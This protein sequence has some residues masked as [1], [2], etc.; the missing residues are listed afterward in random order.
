MENG[1]RDRNDVVAGKLHNVFSYT[2]LPTGVVF[3]ILLFGVAVHAH[4][5]AHVVGRAIAVYCAIVSVVMTTLLVY[6]HLMTYTQPSQQRLIIRILLMVPIYAVDSCLAL[7]NYRHAALV[8]LVRDTYEAY[9]I[10]N[11]FHLLMAY[12]GGEQKALAAKTGTSVKHIFPLCC[13]PDFPLSQ[14]TM[15]FWKL[16]LLQYLIVKPLLAI[17]TLI[18]TVSGHYDEATWSFG[19]AYVYFVFILNLSVTLAFTCLVYFFKEFRAQL[20]W[21]SPVGKFAAVKAVVFLSFWQGVLAGLLVH[22]GVI[23]GS[24]EGLWTKDEVATGV[25]DFLICI[26]ML[27]MCFVHHTVFPETPYITDVGYQ[28]VKLSTVVHAMSMRDI[29]RNFNQALSEFREEAI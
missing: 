27:A 18:L 19:G 7:W 17:I 13:L 15:V 1:F 14:K 10:Y 12:L 16:C 2:A 6:L 21:V 20:E 29:G 28:R 4:M 11:F 23:T 8:G 3:G 26:E 9:V 22:L 24:K 25:Q 5:E